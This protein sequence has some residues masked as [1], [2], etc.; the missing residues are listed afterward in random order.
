M[1]STTPWQNLDDAWLVVTIH[2]LTFLVL[3][4]LAILVVVCLFVAPSDKKRA[5]VIM[6]QAPQQLLPPTAQPAKQQLGPFLSRILAWDARLSGIIFAWS[7]P[8]FLEVLLSIPGNLMGPPSMLLWAPLLVSTTTTTSTAL[9]VVA[10][11][12]TIK[13]CLWYVLLRGGGGGGNGNNNLRRS[14]LILGK[15]FYGNYMFAVCPILGTGLCYYC[16]STPRTAAAAAAGYHVISVYVLGCTAVLF[17]KHATGRRRPCATDDDGQVCIARKHLAVL[18]QLWRQRQSADTSFPSGDA[19]AAT[20]IALGLVTASSSSGHV[21]T[22]CVVAASLVSST[23]LGR[24]YFLAHYVLDVVGG[25]TVAV[26]VHVLLLLLVTVASSATTTIAAP[27]AAMTW[28]HA[29]AAHGIFVTAAMF[30]KS[31]HK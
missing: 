27:A 22:T 8:W 10:A 26:S 29:L 30:R 20:A 14:K 12:V 21:A 25:V 17:V 2:C 31:D 7:L 19:M 15:V 23:C 3:L 28:Q 1:E 24:V 6:S 13:L 16:C 9:F 4:L 11:V 18:P 5:G